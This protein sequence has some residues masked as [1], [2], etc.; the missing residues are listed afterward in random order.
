MN[1]STGFYGTVWFQPPTVMSFDID[2]SKLQL[3]EV[4]L[5]KL[6]S[7]YIA[8]GQCHSKFA[9]LG[10]DGMLNVLS[11]LQVQTHVVHILGRI[12]SV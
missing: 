12:F 4:L 10:N 5:P 3:T 6:G 8:K 11:S 9:G 1:L 2:N 7:K